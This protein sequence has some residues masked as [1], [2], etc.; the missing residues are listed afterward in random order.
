ML[1]GKQS[2][3]SFSLLHSIPLC[4]YIHSTTDGCFSY[5]HFGA[6][7]IPDATAIFKCLLV[8][9]RYKHLGVLQISS[10]NSVP[11]AIGP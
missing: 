2:L 3:I 6:V 4:V 8:G 7:T 10:E 11:R 1:F 5:F 9:N